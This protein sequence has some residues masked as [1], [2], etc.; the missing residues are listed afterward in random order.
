MRLEPAGAWQVLY[1][2]GV[3]ASRPRSAPPRGA[4]A[5]KQPGAGTRGGGGGT[6]RGGPPGRPS[7]PRPPRAKPT[8][9]SGPSP[10]APRE[11]RVGKGRV[12]WGW[13]W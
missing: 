3:A 10:G 2:P 6:W 13:G 5:G 9:Q 7:S 4:A 11:T 1:S 12:E 8:P